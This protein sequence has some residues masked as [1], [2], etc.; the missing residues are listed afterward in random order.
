MKL[1]SLFVV[2]MLIAMSFLSKVM[3]AAPYGFGTYGNCDYGSVSGCSISIATSG[4]VN[5]PISAV[6]GGRVSI[7]SDTVNV[8]TNSTEGYTLTMANSST[9]ESG[10][11][12]GVDTI[13]AHSATPASPTA[14][15]LNTWGF[16]I[17]GFLGFGS[18]PTT[19]I[20][21]QASS[22]H[23][24]ASVPL[25][26]V[27]LQIR[28]NTTGAASGEDTTV[29]YGVRAD[30]TIPSGAYSATITYTATVNP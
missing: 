29:W 25:S 21:D 12:S 14:L 15:A 8:T 23:S 27:P 3:V 5:M 18:G 7:D 11:V 17:D 28:N 16:R 10:L 9:T 19:T 30:N 22:S 1:K 24:F 13:A 2:I 4:E 6:S 20:T 26:G